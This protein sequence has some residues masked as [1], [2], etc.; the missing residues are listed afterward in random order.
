M[1]TGRQFGTCFAIMLVTGALVIATTQILPQLLQE[2][3]GY[4]ATLAGLAI[5]PGGAVT[6]VAM[7]AVGRLGYVQPRYLIAA[8]AAIACY[9]MVDLFRINSDSDFAYFAWSR[10]YLGIGLPLLFIPITT[11]SYDGIPPDKTDQASALINLARNFGGSMGVAL[12]QTVLARREQFHQSRLVE[13][14]GSWNPFYNDTLSRI[15]G[16]L[17][18]RAAT[19]SSSG[20]STAIINQMVQS[21][22]TLLAYIDV[23]VA[24]AV[25]AMMM[26]PLALTLRAVNRSAG[27]KSAQ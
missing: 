25:I 2:E 26:V 13:H 8:G 9:A 7:V 20:T 5:S 16:Y 21:Q 12:S 4:T 18:G 17:N 1:L 6:M 22:A 27:S 19:G 23:F 14:V 11:A 10:V 24:L 15:Q 3:F